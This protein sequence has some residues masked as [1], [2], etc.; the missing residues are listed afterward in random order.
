MATIVAKYNLYLPLLLA[1]LITTI[2]DIGVPSA[3]I[4]FEDDFNNTCAKSEKSIRDEE[5]VDNNIKYNFFLVVVIL[6]FK[7]VLTTLTFSADL[8][9]FFNEQR[10]V[11]YSTGVY[12]W[13]KAIVELIPT[14]LILMCFSYIGD[15]YDSKHS[16]FT[17]YFI[18]L[19]IGALEIQSLGHF[20]G[21]LFDGQQ[22]LAVFT[23]IGVFI[24]TFLFSNFLI[25]INELHYS[26]QMLSMLSPLKLVLECIMLA[27]YGFDRCSDR[28]FSF[29]LHLFDV[30]DN[31]FYINTQL[32][33]IQ[34]VVVRSAS[35]IAL[36][37][38]VSPFVNSKKARDIRLMYGRTR[39]H[40]KAFIPG[41]SPWNKTD[42]KNIYINNI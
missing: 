18:F 31:D 26:L 7:L 24:V 2:P 19:T 42:V 39:E 5:L 20:I 21:I 9:T 13:S 14:V 4:N 11:W 22:R 27:F 37:L 10:N 40:S 41:F 17:T 28:E 29:V 25:P 38:K 30:T 32:L 1:I 35:L 34:F 16:M 6:F 3:C 12:Y 15:I 23:S 33:V 8:K 36:L